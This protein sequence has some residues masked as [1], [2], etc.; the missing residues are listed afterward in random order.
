MK[1]SN[2]LQTW[3]VVIMV[4]IIV[5]FILLES[6]FW[7]Q[8][9]KPLGSCPPKLLVCSVSAIARSTPVRKTGGFPVLWP[10]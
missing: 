6:P 10:V 9:D 3:R 8:E 2:D 1:T 5:I 4:T 7:K